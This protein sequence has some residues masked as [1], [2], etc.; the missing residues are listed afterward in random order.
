METTYEIMNEMEKELN[1][2]LQVQ[3][4]RYKLLGYTEDDLILEYIPSRYFSTLHSDDVTYTEH[5]EVCLRPKTT[6]ERER[7]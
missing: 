2:Y 3:L 7:K 5:F 4:E 6:E 1:E